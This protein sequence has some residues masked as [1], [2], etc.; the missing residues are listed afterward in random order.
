VSTS[1]EALERARSGQ[2]ASNYVA[3]I[4][5]FMERG[6]SENQIIPRVNVFTYHAWLALNRPVRKGE[7]G[8]AIVTWVHT[9]DKKDTTGKVTHK[10]RSYPRK[11]Y[12]FHVSQTDQNS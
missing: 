3:I 8:V 7:R 5:G 11:A 1:T 10:G 2:T 6:I 4:S 9:D 12:V